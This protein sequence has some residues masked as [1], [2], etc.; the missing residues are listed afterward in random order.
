MHLNRFFQV[1]FHVSR[2]I[3]A[4]VIIWS[5]F[6]VLGAFSWN[7]WSFLVFRSLVGVGEAS[8]ATLA[9]PLL[10]DFFDPA[11]RS[12]VLSI[13]FI[14]IPVGAALGYGVGGGIGGAFGWRWAFAV[15]GI[16]GVILALLCLL[17][18]EDELPQKDRQELLRQSGGSVNSSAQVQELDVRPP[19][20][21][22]SSSS[23]IKIVS[24]SHQPPSWL[25]TIRQLSQNRTY[26]LSITAQTLITFGVG[27]M[28][29]WFPTWLKRVH[30]MSTGE[31][32][33]LVG[34]VTCVGGIVGTLMGSHVADR[35]VGVIHNSYFFVCATTAFVATVLLA[36]A[37]LLPG[38]N[39][40]LPFVITMV[41]FG[42]IFLWCFQGPSNAE[43]ANSVTDEQRVRAFALLI[44]CQH[45]FGD[46]I[47]PTIIG[48]GSP[49]Q[50]S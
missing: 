26:L 23:D 49:W 20:I 31:A 18:C 30:H 1:S 5:A 22:S 12:K 39:Q 47:S 7:F 29:D 32:G 27:G 38:A 42:E 36:S 13:F 17:I 41:A 28:A 10:S 11:Y 40:S 19:H 25:H 3:C 43:I 4:G 34:M 37:V 2:L 21:A 15:C 6:T 45:A 14:A 8:F 35:L 48:L 50:K 33:V 16:P 44:L 9:P 46:A 24:E